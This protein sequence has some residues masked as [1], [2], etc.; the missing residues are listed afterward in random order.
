LRDWYIN[1]LVECLDITHY[2]LLMSVLQRICLCSV[3]FYLG[4]TLLFETLA[5]KLRMA[6]SAS[7][8]VCR[9]F[10]RLV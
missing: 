3:G 9:A 6:V 4:S 8:R 2:P 5:V 7:L 10:I 1:I